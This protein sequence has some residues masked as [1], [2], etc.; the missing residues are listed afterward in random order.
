MMSDVLV[1]ILSA[2]DKDGCELFWTTELI[3]RFPILTFV[4]E[5]VRSLRGNNK[6]RG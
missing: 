3:V 2:Y 1:A 5:P 6:H 4:G